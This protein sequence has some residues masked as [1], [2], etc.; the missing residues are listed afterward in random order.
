[1]YIQKVEVKNVPVKEV[2]REQIREQLFEHFS[3]FGEV[4]DVENQFDIKSPVQFWRIPSTSF[5]LF[6]SM[7][8]DVSKESMSKKI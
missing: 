3:F 4:L 8:S 2:N 5:K 1:M 7:D 6:I